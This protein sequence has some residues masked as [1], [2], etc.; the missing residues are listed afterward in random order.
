[1]AQ[2]GKREGA[3]RKRVERLSD[4][5]V[6]AK[7]LR[8]VHAEELEKACIAI[9]CK[10]L[11]IDLGKKDR[12]LKDAPMNVSILPLSKIIDR[13]KC[14]AFGNPRDMTTVNHV[15]DKPVEL[16]V[17]ISMSELV[18]KVRERKQEYERSGK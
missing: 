7:I 1:M 2:G 14:H 17:T 6:S 16:N 11:G 3:G 18:R 10:R 4:P 13:L 15:H 8:D 9:E 5:N 12:G